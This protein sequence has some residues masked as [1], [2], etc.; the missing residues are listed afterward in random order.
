VPQE[1]FPAAGLQVGE[2]LYVPD[3]GVCRVGP[4]LEPG[5]NAPAAVA[6]QRRGL[7][8]HVYQGTAGNCL[9]DA[10]YHHPVDGALDHRRAQVRLARQ[11]R[12]SYG[13][14]ARERGVHGG[15]FL[16]QAFRFLFD[17]VHFDL[18]PEVVAAG[19]QT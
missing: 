10:V 4:V 5:R 16:A 7:E 19:D 15:H 18:R 9:H 1:V 8:P 17:A 13:A 11:C 3:L 12:K 14:S 6:V 2:R